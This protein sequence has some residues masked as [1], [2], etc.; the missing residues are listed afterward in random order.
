MFDHVLGRADEKVTL[1]DAHD[2]ATPGQGLV[3]SSTV[4]CWRKLSIAIPGHPSAD[5]HGGARVHG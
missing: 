5:R 4:E 2:R 1:G 3:V